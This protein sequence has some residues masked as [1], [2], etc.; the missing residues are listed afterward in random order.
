MEVLTFEL[1]QRI[2]AHMLKNKIGFVFYQGAL[3]SIDDCDTVI[4]YVLR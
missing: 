1:A 3:I 2:K 4:N